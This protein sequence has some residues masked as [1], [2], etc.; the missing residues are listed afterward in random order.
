MNCYTIIVAY[1]GTDFHGWQIQPEA[2]TIT[3]ALQAAWSSLFCT[4]D[5][6]PILG[7]SRTDAGVHALGQVARFHAELPA[8]MGLEKLRHAWNARL[9]RSIHI[10]SITPS[11]DRFHPC[12]NVL[13]KTYNY[14]LFLK[15]PLPFVAR[16]GW[17][18]RF[19][20]QVDFPTFEKTLTLYQG[21]HD[22]A[23]FCKVEDN[24][25]S[26][27]RTI[28]SISCTNMKRWGAVMVTIK[29]PSFVRFQIR[30]MVG[31]AL[32]ASRKPLY[33]VDHIKDLLQNP[34]PEQT[35]VKAD[36]Q[37]LCLRKIVYKNSYDK[38]E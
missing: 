20:N 1:D 14:V 12:G 25:K 2:I 7:A 32:D 21:T 27:I 28:D 29:G 19:I 37:G 23:S 36:G 13:Q 34:N 15:R 5:V 8:E 18:Y 30:R 11:T 35:L 9:P 17:Q 10:R 6:L 22:F 4:Q 26:T 31:Y 38:P 33:A 3:S 16:Y 24:D